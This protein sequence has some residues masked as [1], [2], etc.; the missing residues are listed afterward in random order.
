MTATDD[1]VCIECIAQLTR[2]QTGLLPD[3]DTEVV[4]EHL[5]GCPDCRL[6]SEQLD[7][8]RDF[9]GDLPAPDLPESLSAFE[10]SSDAVMAG[11]YRLANRIDPDNASDLVQ[12]T[13]LAA[14]E[15]GDGSLDLP[16]LARNLV[17]AAGANPEPTIG[18]LQQTDDKVD[19]E[20]PDADTAELFYPD[21]YADG[22][23]AGRFVDAPVAW[24]E[25]QVLRPD[26]DVVATELFGI[27][28]DALDG[29]PSPLGELVALVD[30]DG[31]SV[32]SAAETIGLSIDDAVDGLHRA[33]V[34][35]RE[36]LAMRTRAGAVTST[37][38]P[39]T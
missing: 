36:L 31:L 24:G 1:L 33:R 20:D 13:L 15:T 19:S 34:H 14:L 32:E 39:R 6:F 22:P 28:D 2:Y 29:F 3:D 27:V 37:R 18:S 8:T 12:T 9:L 25:R 11:L 30:I 21:F 17:A 7:A 5:A 26:D 4:D 16:T 35:L 23:D 10:H 38:D